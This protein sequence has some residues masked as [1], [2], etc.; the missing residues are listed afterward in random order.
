MIVSQMM[1]NVFLFNNVIIKNMVYFVI[2]IILFCMMNIYL[3][4]HAG[5]Y[6][7]LEFFPVKFK[8]II[9][10]L[11]VFLHNCVDAIVSMFC[12]VC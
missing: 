5:H 3:Q 6:S 11:Q 8:L 12:L 7:D 9:V 10:F 4:N 1:I 2:K